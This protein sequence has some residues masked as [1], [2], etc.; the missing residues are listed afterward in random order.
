MVKQKSKQ[1]QTRKTFLIL[2]EGETE[3]W[4]LN[5]LKSHESETL[6]NIQINIEPKLPIKKRL[7]LLLTEAKRHS[8]T[9]YK[10]YVILDFD[11]ILNE[12]SQS[13][14]KNQTKLNIPLD[15]LQEIQNQKSKKI[16][17]L[18]NNPCLEVWFLLHFIRTS[19]PF[20]NC[21]DVVND[22]KN[23]L[24][25]Y[26][27]S[28]NYYNKMHS[29]IYKRLRNKLSDAILNAETLGRF[30]VQNLNKTLAELYVLFRDLR[31]I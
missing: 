31:I 1:R 19:R 12:Y 4:Y 28:Y 21:D 5:K 16:E 23:Y 14:D 7:D 27:K 11:V 2:V 3:L 13:Q 30:D 25:D 8:K 9:Y 24:N 22:F 18:I 15:F 10:V 17:I 6:T 26:A 20:Q 29:D